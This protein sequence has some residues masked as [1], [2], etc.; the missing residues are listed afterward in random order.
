MKEYFGER[1][2]EYTFHDICLDF[3]ALR[4]FLKIR[5][6]SSGY[7]HI[8]QAGRVGLPTIIIEDQMIIGFDEEEIYRFNELNK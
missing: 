5:D 4:D 8:R 2:I 6:N 7:D 3:Q 1:N